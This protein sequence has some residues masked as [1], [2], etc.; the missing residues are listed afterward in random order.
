M[1][2]IPPN[3][4]GYLTLASSWIASGLDLG[5]PEDGRWAHLLIEACRQAGWDRE[6]VLHEF[7]DGAALVAEE[8]L[9]ARRAAID[10][11]R[12]GALG[13]PEAVPGTTSLCA[14]DSDGLGVS[15]IQS[16]AAG[17]GSGLVVPGVRVFLQNRGV[18]FS[19][20]EGH[21]AEYGPG[22]RPPHTLA[23]LLVTRS[24][25]SLRLLANTMGGDSQPQVLTQLLARHLLAGQGIGET[26]ASGRW[27]LRSSGPGFSGFD[28]WR[29]G[30]DKVTV[31]L[32]G[33]SP[34]AWDEAL[35]NRGHQVARLGPF[36]GGFG[37]SELIAV[38]DNGNYAGA[39]DPRALG[40]GVAAY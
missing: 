40:S 18:G 31:E 17:F 27:R 39:A 8:R 7:A 12:A 36:D 9:S 19:L 5:D 20:V 4:Q 2:T 6:Q 22:R 38:E 10:P 15:L 30:G 34:A 35:A 28:T 32:E 33:H 23:P 29:D 21:P 24:D 26:M 14:I 16:N 13:W 25:G 11:E 1:W 3:S 37:H